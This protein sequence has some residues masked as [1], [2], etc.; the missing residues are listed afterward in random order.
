MQPLPKSPKEIVV[1]QKR[2]VVPLLACALVSLSF[3]GT[4]R[5][6]QAVVFTYSQT[7]DP[8]SAL[9]NTN[10]P[11]TGNLVVMNDINA[12]VDVF[13]IKAN[14]ILPRGGDSNDRATNLKLDGPAPTATDP[15]PVAASSLKGHFDLVF[16]WDAIDKV[17]A[18]DKDS[19]LWRASFL[20]SFNYNDPDT[21]KL[22]SGATQNVFVD[23]RV[24]DPGFVAPTPIPAALPLFAGGLGLMGVVTRRRK[25]TF[26]ATAA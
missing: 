22:I 5:P 17:I 9:E 12:E 6:A 8:F 2:Y 13:S 21:G 18:G 19:G 11:Q 1:R 15:L 14:L 24:T 3:V 4:A 23:L 16:N 26:S 10:N 25:R 20:L 7:P